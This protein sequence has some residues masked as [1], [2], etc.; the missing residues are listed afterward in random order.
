MNGNFQR[1]LGTFIVAAGVALGVWKSVPGTEAD[2]LAFV[3]VASG[4]ANGPLFLSGDGSRAQPWALRTFSST[5][6]TDKRQAP[7]I[8]SIGDDPDRVFQSSPP[9]PIDLAVVFSNF[10]RLGAR[11]AA[12]AAVLAWEKPDPIGLAALEKS[13]DQFDSLVLCAPLSRG[14]VTTPMPPS[15]RRTSLPMTAIHGDASVLPL[16]NRLPVPGILLTGD[17]TIAGFSVLESEPESEKIPLMA[18]WEDRVVFAF[19]LV[20]LLQRMDLP[21]EGVE[22]RLGEYLKLGPAGPLVPVDR[23]GRLTDT[24][25]LVSP[26]E[27]IPAEELIDGGDELFPKQAPDPVIVRDD[28]SA[29]DPGT[30]AFSE[31]LS[32]VIAGIASNGG[33]SDPREFVRLPENGEAAMLAAVVVALAL[34][35]GA[36]RFVR[37][38]ST[39]AMLGIA[40]GAQWLAF[41][42]GSIW[43]PGIA[44]LAAG[45]AAGLLGFIGRRKPAMAGPAADPNAP[46]PHAIPRPP[47]APAPILVHEEANAAEPETRRVP[48]SQPIAVP[49]AAPIPSTVPTP[50]PRDE[51]PP[52]VPES[53]PEKAPDTDAPWWTKYE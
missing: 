4:S 42:V 44:I 43:L 2:R 38:M 24:P 27:T 8:V 52:A 47:L 16:V 30:R 26:Y 1:R 21:L 11:K 23:F 45:I 28:Q 15:F 10:H 14:V 37:H 34:F 5:P 48:E 29:A 7:V 33:L 22:V 13:L 46:P 17:E 32:S 50:P 3:A 19:P 18:R 6:R 9:S 12:S 41:S 51:A 53:T 40:L 31:Q 25:K 36:S 49:K 39:L 35:G 20:T